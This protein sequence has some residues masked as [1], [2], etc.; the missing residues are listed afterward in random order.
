[1]E[2]VLI[3]IVCLVRAIICAIPGFI[4]G[5]FYNIKEK[6]RLIFLIS[7][8]IFSFYLALMRPDDIEFSEL[9]IGF[10]E[11]FG[12]IYIGAFIFIAFRNM[13]YKFGLC[14]ICDKFRRKRENSNNN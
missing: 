1:M 7:A 5:F 14:K 13:A 4:L 3:L 11:D 8:T 10:L 12:G 6:K 2:I 9:M